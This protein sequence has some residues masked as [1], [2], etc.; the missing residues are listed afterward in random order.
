MKKLICILTAL[1][2]AACG[3]DFSTPASQPTPTI[4]WKT[5]TSFSGS[6][7]ATS[8]TFTVPAHWRI[9]WSCDP[10]SNKNQIY[11]VIVYKHKVPYNGDTNIPQADINQI[12][13]NESTSGETEE[14]GTGSY[15]LEIDT[16][17][18]WKITIQTPS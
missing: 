15:Y 10:N 12:C 7:N 6:G 17:D 9:A 5:L 18:A 3:P 14:T 8:P 11:N 2:L 4:K 13:S 1:L 16:E